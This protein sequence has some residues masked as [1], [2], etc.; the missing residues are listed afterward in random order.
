L[1]DDGANAFPTGEAEPIL[2]VRPEDLFRGGHLPEA[3]SIPADELPSRLHEL[4]PAGQRLTVV[5]DAD[6]RLRVEPLLGRRYELLWVD[7]ED[8]PPSR[9]VRGESRGRLWRPTA[10][11]AAWIDRVPV[12]GALDLGCGSGRDAVFL[13]EHGHDVLAV[14]RLPDALERAAAL[15]RRQGVSIRTVCADLRRGPP[16]DA[17]A[18]FE[19]IGCFY[20][21]PRGL[22]EV[23]PDALAPGGVLLIQTFTDEHAVRFGRPRSPDRVVRAG[24]LPARLGG[25][26]VLLDRCLWLR[27][28]QHVCQFAARRPAADGW[29]A[30]PRR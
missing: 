22:F 12:G 23:L 27:G 13:A 29:P 14:D 28:R 25:L 8:V 30:K 20:F 3:A 7:P 19:V 2:D 15:A 1:S 10:L 26:E 18:Q 24:E 17:G 4:P 11:L 5:A 21:L 9:R 6:G 16:W